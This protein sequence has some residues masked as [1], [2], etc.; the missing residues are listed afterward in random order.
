M[1]CQDQGQGQG[2]DQ[3]QD[4]ACLIL[5]SASPQR[6]ELLAQAGAAPAQAVPSEI[7][8]L[9]L[10]KEQPRQYTAR[11]AR[12]KA[13]AVADLFPGCFVLGADTTVVLG[14]RILQK[15]ETEAQAQRFLEMLSGRRHQVLGGVA[16]V[17]PK[18]K[19]YERLVTT[20]VA[21]KRLH[22]D[23][24]D[25]YIQSGQWK[26]KAGAYAIQGRAAAFVRKII[27]SYSNVVGLPLFET[28]GLLR[29]LGW[30]EKSDT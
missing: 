15:A 8:E 11:I 24:I 20:S 23:E 13:M 17:D 5:A 16:I 10:K 21:F 14:R 18:G 26:D 7:D 9:P 27:G 19:I 28:L 4:Q 2:Q 1:P 25:A 3:G 12:A 22:P 30:K 29:G 6:G